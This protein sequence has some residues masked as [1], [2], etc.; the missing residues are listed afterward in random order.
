M[1]VR[2]GRRRRIFIC[3]PY[4]SDPAT[5]AAIVGDCARAIID[6]GAQPIAPQLYL[7]QLVSEEEERALALE[8]CLDLLARCDEVRV[9]GDVVSAGM[10]GEISLAAKYG[11]P[12]TWACVPPS[13]GVQSWEAQ[14]DALDAIATMRGDA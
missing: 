3:H 12:V 4:A 10:R 6:E 13:R 8:L 11:I 14:R 7:A 9:F 1:M 5:N 2:P